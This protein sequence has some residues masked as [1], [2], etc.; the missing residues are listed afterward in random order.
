ML[1]SLNR[2]D[3]EYFEKSKIGFIVFLLILAVYT[4]IEGNHLGFLIFPIFFLLIF[5]FILSKTFLHRD[6]NVRKNL[7]KNYP[8][9]EPI[10]VEYKIPINIQSQ[11]F[12]P[13]CGSLIYR[14]I[15]ENP[16]NFCYHCGQEIKKIRI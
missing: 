8:R 10:R 16:V 14:F 13:L 15:G 3:E 1:R 11:I 4:V 2:I 9:T 5:V 6:F 7:S 12:C